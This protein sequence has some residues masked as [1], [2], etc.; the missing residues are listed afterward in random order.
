V[1]PQLL[2]RFPGLSFIISA[3]IAIM[4]RIYHSVIASVGLALLLSVELGA[5]E[6]IEWPDTTG[7]RPAPGQVFADYPGSL[8][9]VINLDRGATFEITAAGL[10]LLQGNSRC[11][12]RDLSNRTYGSTF[13]LRVEF[14]KDNNLWTGAMPQ[15]GNAGQQGCWA[16]WRFF[17][18]ADAVWGAPFPGGHSLSAWVRPSFPAIPMVPQGPQDWASV[19]IKSN[20]R[21]HFYGF[22]VE[23]PGQYMVRTANDCSHAHVVDLQFQTPTGAFVPQAPLYGSRR[24]FDTVSASAVPTPHSM[25]WAAYRIDKPGIYV[26]YLRSSFYLSEEPGARSWGGPDGP[27]FAD[28]TMS[29][30]SP[31]TVAGP[32]AEAEA[33]AFG[34]DD[35]TRIPS[36]GEGIPPGIPENATSLFE[37]L[38]GPTPRP[39]L[40]YIVRRDDAHTLFGRMSASP[41]GWAQVLGTGSTYTPLSFSDAGAE[42]GI[43]F[44]LGGWVP[45]R[46]RAALV[47]PAGPLGFPQPI[48]AVQN[49]GRVESIGG[50]PMTGSGDSRRMLVFGTPDREEDGVFLVGLD[51]LDMVFRKGACL[52]EYDDWREL[53]GMRLPFSWTQTCPRPRNLSDRVEKGGF[54]ALRGFTE[55]P[56]EEWFDL[57]AYSEWVMETSGGLWVTA[58]NPP[59]LGS[60]FDRNYDR[61]CASENFRRLPVRELVEILAEEGY[62]LADAYYDLDCGRPLLFWLLN[63]VKADGIDTLWNEFAKVGR[64]SDFEGI[65]REKDSSGRG[66]PREYWATVSRDWGTPAE[67]EKIDDYVERYGH[68]CQ[69]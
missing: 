20:S 8:P 65:W 54:L 37:W 49:L 48:F 25:A 44:T 68:L 67:R 11:N 28:F 2:R 57:Q 23:Q 40:E 12:F 52:T 7:L 58:V 36:Y 3:L 10:F 5:Q 32:L 42:V 55:A 34:A 35:W 30:I 63:Q 26:Q 59:N 21:G 1:E 50:G 41:W 15:I 51:R 62:E 6:P 43:P 45:T 46:E 61:M 13:S 9:R 4:Q 56:T 47:R 33:L 38:I 39:A 64:L 27:C 29:P 60:F 17:P 16:A 22:K 19:H 69:N 14:G 18:D 66:C 24:T 31:E 53:E